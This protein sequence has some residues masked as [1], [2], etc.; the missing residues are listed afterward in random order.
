MSRVD[1]DF[2][3]RYRRWRQAVDAAASL[4]SDDAAYADTPELAA[5]VALGPGAVPRVLE[6]LESDPGA[7]FLV[8]ALARITGHRFSDEELEAARARAGGV[9]GNQAMAQLWRGWWRSRGG[10]AEAR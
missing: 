7:H 2:E 5:I 6:K 10:A 9:L 3:A 1:D 8:H 4:R